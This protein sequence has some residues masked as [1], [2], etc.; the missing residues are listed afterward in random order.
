MAQRVKDTT[1]L[2]HTAMSWVTM[3][4]GLDPWPRKLCMLYVQEKKEKKKKH[5]K[6][7]EMQQVNAMADLVLILVKDH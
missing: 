5:I 6:A 4:V 2:S 1:L 3:V 7:K